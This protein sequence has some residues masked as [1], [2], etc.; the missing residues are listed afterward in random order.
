MLCDVT[1][2]AGLRKNGRWQATPREAPP[3]PHCLSTS[4]SEQSL[5]LEHF[6]LKIPSVGLK[7]KDK[8]QTEGT[9]HKLQ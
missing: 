7:D 3:L 2:A 8:R 4:H 5:Q 6:S 9:K 1:N